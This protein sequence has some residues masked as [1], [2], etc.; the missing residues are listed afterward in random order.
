MSRTLRA[1]IGGC[2]LLAVLAGCG[3]GRPSLGAVKDSLKDHGVTGTDKALTCAAK[4]I[5]DSKMS[6]AALRN[7]IDKDDKNDRKLSAS[8]KSAADDALAKV[9]DCG[10]TSDG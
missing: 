5:V 6:D 3:G 10:L 1:G 7:L 9:A 2:L 4:A 8:D